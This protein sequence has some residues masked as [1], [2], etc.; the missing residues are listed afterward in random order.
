M[1]DSYKLLIVDEFGIVLERDGTFYRRDSGRPHFEQKFTD[2]E[3]ATRFAESVVREHPHVECVVFC[4]DQEVFR[5]SDD[6]W[7]HAEGERKR[8]LFAERRRRDKGAVSAVI[9]SFA[10]LIVGVLIFYFK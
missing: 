1:V 4:G 5:H 7:R 8:L 2:L 3:A 9:V 10:L 6:E